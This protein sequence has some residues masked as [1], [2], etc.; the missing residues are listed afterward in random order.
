MAKKKIDSDEGF[1]RELAKETGGEV[2]DDVETVKYFVDT[3]SLSINYICSGKFL[4]GG[5]PGGRITELYG[6]SS[7]SKSLLGSNLLFGIQRMGGISI[8]IDTENAANKEFIVRASHADPKKINR[9]KTV[10]L[11]KCFAKIHSII[12]FV[13]EKKPNIPVLIVYDSLSVSPT[14][15]EL[16]EVDLPEKFNK[17]E[18]KRI[19]G[20]KEQP[21]ERAKVCS[22]EL[23]KL[24]GLMEKV[25]TNCTVVF[26][27]QTRSQ[28][29]VMYGN[30]E[31]K[32]GGGNALTFYASL[33]LRT[34][35]LKKIEQKITAKKKRILGVNV[36]IQNK[37]NRSY[38]PFVETDGIKL[39]FEH[40]IN[41]LSG[42]LSLMLDCKRITIGGKGT[43]TVNPEYSGGEVVKFK[44]NLE[45]NNVPLDIFLKCPAL[46]DASSAQ[47]ITDYLEPFQSALSFENDESIIETSVGDD[48]EDSISDEIDEMLENI[49]DDEDEDDESE[50]DDE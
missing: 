25:N 49:E 20:G 12:K 26:M 50:E 10:S 39:M 6:P 34:Q 19:V 45:E 41:P 3:G 5:I 16:R 7:S 4:G 35:T 40:G 33:I 1:M 48:E 44:A 30:P 47:E 11:E 17:A 46:L 29:G 15:R 23:R 8:L 2:L 36:R 42:L 37:K 18:F 9:Y 38:R 13:R 21:G 43:F 32:G 22:K 28:I 14:E 24:N 31:T 27:N